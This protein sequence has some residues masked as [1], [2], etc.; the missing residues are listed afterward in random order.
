MKAEVTIAFKRHLP[1]HSATE[2]TEH[3]SFDTDKSSFVKEAATLIDVL[4]KHAKSA[5]LVRKRGER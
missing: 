4:S 2:R 3:A 1:R 5:R